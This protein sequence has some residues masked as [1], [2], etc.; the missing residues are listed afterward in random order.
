MSGGY[1]YLVLDQLGAGKQVVDAAELQSFINSW[2]PC[3][4]ITNKLRQAD[5]PLPIALRSLP[6]NT[7]MHSIA[8]Q[9]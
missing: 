7:S 1:K 8:R 4:S 2:Q 3:L 6:I 5:M 9:G